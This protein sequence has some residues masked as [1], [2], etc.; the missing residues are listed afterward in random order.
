M[1]TK[2]TKKT[3]IKNKS[4]DLKVKESV[5]KTSV[6]KSKTRASVKVSTTPDKKD[7]SKKVVVKR[8]KLDLAPTRASAV[9]IASQANRAKKQALIERV[10]ASENISNTEKISSSDAKIPLWVWVFFGCSL[11][12]FCVSFYKAIVRP[13]IE[14][15]NWVSEETMN[16]VESVYNDSQDI[17]N[18]TEVNLVE[19]NSY[20]QDAQESWTDNVSN[21]A[22]KVIEEFFDRLSNRQFDDAFELMIPAL[23]NSS[24][25]K[26]HF[27]SF[28]MNPF[29]DWIEW[30]RL[31]PVNF[32]Y[33]SSSSSWK[34]K[35]NFDLKYVMVSDKTEYD[36]TW[37]FTVN[38][39][40]LKISSI[41]CVTSK[42]S[43]HPIF[44]PENFGLM[45]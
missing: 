12:L 39:W 15:A 36:E 43:F 4:W 37:E 10:A 30:W 7:S 6:S 25:I 42:C 24:E 35:Y 20:Q 29:L 9:A 26:I 40:D 14:K 44:W 16:W 3:S 2:T 38:A 41:R 11:L 5:A 31:I 33:V 22:T 13:Q 28:R 23:R 21:V 19:E 1:P 27:T 18:V 45:R 34:D 32:Q 8:R 17:D